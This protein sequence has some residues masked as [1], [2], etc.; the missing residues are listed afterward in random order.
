VLDPDQ[1]ITPEITVVTRRCGILRWARRA[2]PYGELDMP[3][4]LSAS[5]DD[6][7]LLGSE[8]CE[9]LVFFSEE[10]DRFLPE[11]QTLLEAVTIVIREPWAPETVDGRGHHAR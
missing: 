7:L 3:A 8:V 4:F 9:A 11:L 2:I 10:F 5:D 6:Q 1:V